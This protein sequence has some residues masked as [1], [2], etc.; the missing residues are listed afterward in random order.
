MTAP[1]HGEL[2][3]VKNLHR[4]VFVS[5][6][7]PSAETGWSAY[8]WWLEVDGSGVPVALHSRNAAN[9]GHSFSKGSASPSSASVNP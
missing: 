5:E 8:K 4:P 6:T 9:V 3:E 2:V 7:D 1:I